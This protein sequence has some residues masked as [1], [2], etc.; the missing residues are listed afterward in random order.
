[1]LPELSRW[2]NPA[3]ANRHMPTT[4]NSPQR[5]KSGRPET[6][7]CPKLS[8]CVLAALMMQFGL[9]Q[10]R[11]PIQ[12]ERGSF[13]VNTDLVLV[14]VTVTD[15]QNRPV[16]G[17]MQ[18]DFQVYEAGDLRAITSLSTED[19]PASIILVFDQSR[20]MK[21]K[22]RDARAAALAFVETVNPEDEVGLITFARQTMV[23]LPLGLNNER[24]RDALPLK[25]EDSTALVDAIKLALDMSKRA[26]YKRKAVI[27]L[28]DGGDN[29][30]RYSFAE[31]KASAIESDVQ[32]YAIA[33][34]GDHREESQSDFIL[35]GLCEPTGGRY[36]V[37]R[38][39]RKM[40]TVAERI[41]VLIRNQ[42][43]IGYR[44]AP[45][46][47]GKWVEIKVKVDASGAGKIRVNSRRGYRAP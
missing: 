24:L 29:R 16:V 47:S 27:V 2:P 5:E 34:P 46:Q 19:A 43:L 28:S 32:I 12:P 40:K 1:M 15:R 4:H 8:R 36:V 38:D 13:A 42:Y 9:G 21:S 41:G 10:S 30:S 3:T 39:T 44:P 7:N 14:P 17:L 20:S 26:R 35:G 37:V 33:V 6:M 22:L 23:E 11:I 25:T 45:A 18:R 31:V